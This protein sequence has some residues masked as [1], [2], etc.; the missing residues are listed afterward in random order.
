MC[1][2]VVTLV[3]HVTLKKL[4]TVL[5]LVVHKF[6]EDQSHNC[7]DKEEG[8]KHAHGDDDVAHLGLLHSDVVEFVS[9]GIFVGSHGELTV[10]EGHS[11]AVNWVKVGEWGD[12]LAVGHILL[13]VSEHEI[14]C[15]VLLDLVSVAT[16]GLHTDVVVSRLGGWLSSLPVDNDVSVLSSNCAAAIAAISLLKDWSASSE[17]EVAAKLGASEL[18]DAEVLVTDLVLTVILVMVDVKG[19]GV[20]DLDWI[21]SHAWRELHAV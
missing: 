20:V 19:V 1:S 2:S 10:I 6:V 21:L 17:L 14:G 12:D 8:G 16:V 3:V 7:E 9:E 18:V 5:F 13:L 15:G 4:I 11:E